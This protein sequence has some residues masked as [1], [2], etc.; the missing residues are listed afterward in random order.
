MLT[1]EVG[2]VL[3]LNTQAGFYFTKAASIPLQA[4]FLIVQEVILWVLPP[5]FSDQDDPRTGHSMH[6]IW[7]IKA[8]STDCNA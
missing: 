6:H 5:V 1:T 2:A 8:G 4:L 7:Y 3:R